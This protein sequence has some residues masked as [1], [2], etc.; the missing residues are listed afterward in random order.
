METKQSTKHEQQRVESEQS[1]EVVLDK[2]NNASND[3]IGE[4]DSTGK[5]GILKRVW[6]LF[7]QRP[8]DVIISVGVILAAIG[9][10]F[11]GIATNRSNIIELELSSEDIVK[12]IQSTQSESNGLSQVEKSLQKVE[13][14]PKASIINKAVAEA[15]RLQQVERIEDAIEKWRSIANIAEGV[16]NDLAAGAWFAVGGLWMQEVIE[17]EVHSVYAYDTSLSLRLPWSAKKLS[18][19]DYTN[20]YIIQ[21]SISAYDEA[22]RLKR[23]YAEAYTSRGVARLFLDQPELALV[24]C[25][26]AIILNPYFAEAYNN[27]GVVKWSL[28]QYESAL[29]D[30]NTAIGLKW[31]Q[32]EAHNNRG[33]VRWSLDQPELALDDYNEAIRLNPN[34]AEAYNNRGNVMSK[35]NQHTAAIGDYNVAIGLNPDHFKA[36]INR[37]NAK[38]ALE[39]IEGAK[40][41]FQTALQ[42]V[43]H[44]G[45][46]EIKVYI[47]KR[48]QELN[49]TE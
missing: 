48:I 40:M 26:K 38:V 2:R 9:T 4:N 28:N 18:I 33:V 22:I 17:A 19:A 30:Y 35:L 16:D 43:E 27:R 15:Y 14:E 42:I 39:D 29:D 1:E 11:I 23:D 12:I 49:G 31:D 20:H 37:G 47:Q 24:D 21:R 36:Y 45:E 25:N 6:V 41:D 5:R 46:E 13:N 34:Y 8:I 3:T 44:H 32:A 10:L 7:L